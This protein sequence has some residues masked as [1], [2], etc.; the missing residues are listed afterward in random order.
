MILSI[1]LQYTS[2]N[3]NLFQIDQRLHMKDKTVKL[4]ASGCKT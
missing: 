3:K 1:N 4:T 2:R